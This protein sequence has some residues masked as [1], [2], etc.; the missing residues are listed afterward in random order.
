MYLRQLALLAAALILAVHATTAAAGD[1]SAPRVVLR[2]YHSTAIDGREHMAVYLPAGY[3]GGRRYPVIYVLHGLPSDDTAY[4][5]LGVEG[6][7]QAAEQAGHPAIVVA[8]QGSRPGDRDPEWLDWGPGRDWGSAMA[9]GVVRYVDRNFRTI[10]DRRARALIGISAGA[11]GA[12]D[13]GIHHLSTFSVIQSWSGY[14][15]PTNRAG[16]GPMEL[17]SPQADAAASVHTYVPRLRRSFRRFP[18]SF[19]FYIGDQDTRFLR[20]NRRLHR[21]LLRAGVPHRFA[22]YPGGHERALWTSHM[23]DW[24]T[25]AVDALRTR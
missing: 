19:G 2:S 20:E 14:F 4:Q 11:Y 16:T 18:T 25:H 15:H 24:V 13:I 6:F 21:Q 8:P 10:R 5:R 9:I 1:V 23:A 7:G 17:G 3:D 22:V 12:A